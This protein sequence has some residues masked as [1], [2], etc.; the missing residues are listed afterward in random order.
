MNIRALLPTDLTLLKDP[1]ANEIT[2]LREVSFS[3]IIHPRMKEMTR[4]NVGSLA[5]IIDI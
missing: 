4:T 3:P 5:E 2:S 1:F